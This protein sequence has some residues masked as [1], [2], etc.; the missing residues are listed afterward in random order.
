MRTCTTWR[1]KVPSTTVRWVLRDTSFSRA[2]LTGLILHLQ[3]IVKILFADKAFNDQY[4]LGAVNS[5][6]FARILAQIV[7]YFSAYFQLQKQLASPSSQQPEIQFVVPTGNF[8]DVL[9]GY[10]AKEMGLP[11]NN[12]AIATNEN[13]ILQ[14]FWTSGAY[15]KNDAGS[16]KAAPASSQVE[17]A[18]GSSDGAQQEVAGGVKATLSPAMDIL[19]SSNFE[20][21]LWHLVYQT[22]GVENSEEKAAK[23]GEQI[24]QWMKQLKESGRFEVSKEQLELARR[25]FSAERVSDQQVSGRWRDRRISK[26]DC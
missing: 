9:A 14:R 8:G 19:V 16:A 12:L 17:P 26:L 5:I 15:E 23:A 7:Y 2:V 24:A 21:L 25:D 22:S 20:R 3:D 18:Q 13:D 10:Y 4:R 1:W 11:V 6:N